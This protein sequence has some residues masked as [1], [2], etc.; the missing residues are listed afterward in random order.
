MSYGIRL[1][2]VG[3]AL[4]VTQ[5]TFA[6]DLTTQSRAALRQLVAQNKAAATASSTALAVLVFPNV[7]KAGF[8]V[9]AHG[10]EG[11]LFVNGK[12]AG[13]YRTSAASYGLQAGVQKYGYALF[14]MNQKALDWVNTT[15]G[16]E[17]GSGPSV[18]LV[19]K[20]MA[21]SF[22]TSTMHSGIYAFTFDQK[23][24]MAG[25]GIQGSRIKRIR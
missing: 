15:K 14:F 7:V 20:G 12:T 1:L 5:A 22:T 16:W 10:G 11:R 18:V 13:R 17:I 25:T 23:G 19:D 2:S 8:I 24:L 4:L 9:G 3:A 21:R 6:D